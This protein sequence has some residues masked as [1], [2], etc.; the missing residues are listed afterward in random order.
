MPIGIFPSKNKPCTTDLYL[1][2]RGD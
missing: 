2:Q 1:L